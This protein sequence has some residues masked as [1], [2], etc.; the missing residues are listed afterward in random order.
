MLYRSIELGLQQVLKHVNRSIYP[1]DRYPY[2]Q[3]SYQVFYERDFEKATKEQ[4]RD[5]ATTIGVMYVKGDPEAVGKPAITA[6]G[7]RNGSWLASRGSTSSANSVIDAEMEDE[8]VSAFERTGFWSMNAYYLNHERNR[9]YFLEKQL[10][11]GV[12]EVP[13]FFVEAMCDRVCDTAE[14]S[15][16]DGMR[17][18]C[19]K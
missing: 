14:S 13:V 15:L 17:D 10:N 2:G 5:V 4:E 9:R 12:L 19:K 18:S 3:W 1:E 11:G 7:L 6:D 8:L 16:A